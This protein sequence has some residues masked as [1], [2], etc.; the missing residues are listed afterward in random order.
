[1]EA[2]TPPRHTLGDVPARD[3]YW[4]LHSLLLPGQLSSK[5]TRDPD[6]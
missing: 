1:M 5:N 3:K 6:P 2:D 4:G